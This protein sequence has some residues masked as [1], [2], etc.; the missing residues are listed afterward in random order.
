MPEFRAGDYGPAIASLLGLAGDGHRRMTLTTGPCV[1]EEARSRLKQWK[2]SGLFTGRKI[3][4]GEMAEAATSGLYL[5]FS[6]PDEAHQIAQDIGSTTGSY[7]HGI[8]HRQEPDFGNAAYWFRRVGQHE[9][10]PALRDE[11]AARLPERFKGSKWDPFRFID[12]CEE[13]HRHPD[14]ALSE[15]LEEIQRAEWQL[16]FDYSCHHAVDMTST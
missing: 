15:A 2:A 13:V 9:I 14:R 7:W 10:F 3:L 4:S 8:L 11:A 1:S 5:Y 12:A 16:L 6:C